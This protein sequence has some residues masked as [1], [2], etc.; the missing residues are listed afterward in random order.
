MSLQ[1]TTKE[2]S[3]SFDP[4]AG[5]TFRLLSIGMLSGTGDDW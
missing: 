3:N 4:Q 1:K 5:I 2:D